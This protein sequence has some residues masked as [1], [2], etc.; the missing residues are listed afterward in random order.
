MFTTGIRWL[1]VITGL[2]FGVSPA[3]ATPITYTFNGTLG[4]PYNGSTQFSGTLTYDTDL[5][6]NPAVQP[7]P[8]WSYY[9]GV[10][11]DPSEPPLS[12]TFNLGN[13]P[14]SSFG[15][16]LNDELIVTHTSSNDGVYIQENFQSPAGP[17]GAQ[18]VMA[19]F[20]M[21]NDNLV[22]RAPLGSTSPPTSLDLAGFS[23]GAQLNIYITPPDGQEV[24]VHGTITTLGGET[25]T[26]EP[27]SLLVFSILGA[28]LWASRHMSIQ[29]RR[30]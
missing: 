28:G 4:Q 15:N 21:V 16:I 19:E 5:P 2:V 14:S 23:M 3:F 22:Q 30:P 10:P 7:F 8:G 13:T 9:S 12:L 27:A 18:A 29:A 1:S 25:M 6:L 20:G 17:G 24:F 11:A 26:P